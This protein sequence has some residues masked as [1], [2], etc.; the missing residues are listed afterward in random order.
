M[1]SIIAQGLRERSE[2]RLV[3]GKLRRWTSIAGRNDVG[4]EKRGRLGSFE[5]L[6]V[7]CCA[8]AV[9]PRLKQ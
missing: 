8:V 7:R 6:G 3:G 2:C 1:P 4:V 9:F 5:A